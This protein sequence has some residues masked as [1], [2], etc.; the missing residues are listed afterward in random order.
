MRRSLATIA[1]LGAASLAAEGAAAKT[2]TLSSG[3]PPGGVGNLAQ[4]S[5]AEWIEAN[6]DL[7][8]DVYALTLLNLAETGPGVRDGIADMG[9][10]VTP[11]HLAEFANT[12]LA[13]D[14]SML[15][16]SGTPTEVPGLVMA[17]AIVEYVMLDCPDCRDE[18]AAQNQL[19][20]GGGASTGYNLICNTPIRSVA[21]VADKKMRV[22]AGVFGRWAE[23]FGAV[24]VKVSGNETYEALS[25]GVV[26]CTITSLAEL[27]NFQ[28][29]DV[30]SNV[31]TGVPG[32]VFAGLGTINM[33]LDAWRGLTVAEREV[34]LRAGARATAEVAIG[35][36]KQSQAAMAQMEDR[37]TEVIA[38]PD[39]LKEATEAFAKADLDKI[40]EQFAGAYGVSD[41]PAKMETVAALVEAW[42][43]VYAGIDATD[44][45]AVSEAIWTRVQS[46][47]DPAAY[48][49]N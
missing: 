14:M 13:A 39:E 8:V 37:G 26:D 46:R 27:I 2:L 1:L 24:K 30:V 23:N 48:G 29:F 11:Y 16:T 42:K 47:L 25:Q 28:L 44:V 3:I 40:A 41:V 36:I 12:N 22:G 18:F 19:F 31:V 33:N 43:G 5:V 34:L 7:E 21:D 49:M 35:Y 45:D 10:V 38:A 15:A 17:S 9:Y 20:L 6:S 32:G 4:E